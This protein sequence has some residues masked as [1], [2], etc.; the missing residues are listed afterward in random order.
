LVLTD[1]TGLQ[2]R[3]VWETEV[4]LCLGCDSSQ[5]DEPHAEGS[6]A[7][8]AAAAGD[9]V[10]AGPSVPHHCLDLELAWQLCCFHCHLAGTAPPCFL[11]STFTG[12]CCRAWFSEADVQQLY[13][14]T[15]GAGMLEQL[16]I[17]V[18]QTWDGIGRMP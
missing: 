8:A 1:A 9:P 3:G 5:P 10:H 14:H 15:L 11:C 16:L 2:G 18:G 7:C 17:L 12:V 13:C 4:G 6:G